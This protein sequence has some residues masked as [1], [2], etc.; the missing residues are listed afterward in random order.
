[1]SQPK[2]LLQLVRRPFFR[3]VFILS[4]VL[5]SLMG[6]QTAAAQDGDPADWRA[7]LTC[8]SEHQVRA[9]VQ[10]CVYVLEDPDNVLNIHVI[11]V[12][13]SAP[14]VRIEYLIPKG[15]SMA[16]EGYQICQDPNRP[17]WG[18][19]Q[20]GGC[21][22]PGRTD[23]YPVMPL[24]G[25]GDD[26]SAL[27]LAGEVFDSPNLAAIVN[28]DY[29]APPEYQDHGPEGLLV[30]SGQ[31]LDGADRCDSDFCAVL[32]PWLA[33]G[34]RTDPDTGML[35]A[36]IG[37]LDR[38]SDT[39]PFSVHAGVGGG[40]WLI[41]DGDIKDNDGT[42]YTSRRLNDP[43]PIE[44]CRDRVPTIT[45]I[46]TEFYGN[47]C[48]RTA[49]TATGISGDGRWLF[50]VMN[51]LD[52]NREGM[53]PTELAVF[54]HDQLGVNNAIKFDGG[55]SSKIWVGGKMPN[56]YNPTGSSRQLS[57]YLAI[58]AA[59][60]PDASVLD[61]ITYL[62]LSEGET[63][64]LDPEFINEADFTWKADDGIAM[65][66]KTSL[67]GQD[68]VHDLPDDVAVAPGARVSWDLPADSSGVSIHRF[69]MAHDGTVFGEEAQFLVVVIPEA[70]EERREEIEEQIK[71]FIEEAQETG[72]VKLEELVEQIR[73]FFITE[74]EIWWETVLRWIMER[75]EELAQ[76][77]IDE[78]AS[79]ICCT[80]GLTLVLPAL[81]LISNRRRRGRGV[82]PEE[83][84]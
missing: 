46:P 63:S 52:S 53:T 69:Q 75:L 3:L 61:R 9:S 73:E 23:L 83:E 24:I 62:I 40:P 66:E 22:V 76:W 49:H 43:P 67:F 81:V 51:G 4:S 65:L 25:V 7:G 74:V 77:I 31:R 70:L 84:A 80:P 44:N 47:S 26:P 35:P 30:V 21:Y 14:G 39:F 38:D 60:P 16:F 59:L 13:L 33:I 36:R 64:T 78:L 10:Y 34:K 5:V 29:A 20:G 27:L 56:D 58:Y 68:V 12:D 55:G 2:E 1:M 37:N 72:E 8:P 79:R 57:S 11:G 41:K 6:G 17:E 54:M 45:T 50:F 42:C 82:D 15:Y 32:R 28:A 19:V 71:E 18:S 48:Y